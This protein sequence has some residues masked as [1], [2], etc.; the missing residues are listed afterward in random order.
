MELHRSFRYFNLSL[1]SKKFLR[2][3][4]AID[5]EVNRRHAETVNGY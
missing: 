3:A 2:Q 1:R 5:Q 4:L